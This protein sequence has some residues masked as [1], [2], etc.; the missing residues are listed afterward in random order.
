MQSRSKLRML[1]SATAAIAAIAAGGYGLST[2]GSAG[3]DEAVAQAAPQITPVTVQDVHS[4]SV[5]L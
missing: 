5:R 2:I 1:L 3:A 4:Q